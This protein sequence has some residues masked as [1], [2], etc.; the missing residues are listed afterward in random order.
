MSIRPNAAVCEFAPNVEVSAIVQQA[1]TQ[2]E[3]TASEAYQV[4]E[5]G[6]EG[7]SAII[8]S[9][10]ACHQ[11]VT[12]VLDR[13]LVKSMSDGRIHGNWHILEYCGDPPSKACILGKYSYMESDR[14]E[15]SPG[16][17]VGLLGVDL[18]RPHARRIRFVLLGFEQSHYSR[19]RVV[20]C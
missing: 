8:D 19:G 2:Y 15:R 12:L 4:L 7:H 16:V 13:G 20:P 11:D 3:H 6:L 14:A 18:E 10:G 5:L 9:D 17:E 1:I